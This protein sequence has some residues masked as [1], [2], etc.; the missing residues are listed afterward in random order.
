MADG[1]CEVIN[2]NAALSDQT[3][4][5]LAAL[6]ADAPSFITEVVSIV[7]G[8]TLMASASLSDEINGISTARV[9][10]SAAIG[11]AAFTIG[12]FQGLAEEAFGAADRV[13]FTLVDTLEASAAIT[14]AAVDS[15]PITLLHESATL[16]DV[17]LPVSGRQATALESARL[18]DALVPVKS[19]TLGDA[20]AVSDA[21]LGTL[22]SV[23]VINESGAF[24]DEVTSAG[25]AASVLAESGALSDALQA[26]V[27]A[28]AEVPE[29]ATIEGEAVLAASGAAWAAPTD[30]FAM[31]RWL[32]RDANSIAESDGALLVAGPGGIFR[33]DDGA[34]DAGGE[35][36][37]AQVR[38][39]LGD[40]GTPSLKRTS[41]FYLGYQSAGTLRVT[42][43]S[44]P[45][46]VEESY[47]YLF[48]PRRAEVPVPGKAKLGRG[49]RARYWRITLENVDG[50][51]FTVH[52]ALMD[53]EAMSRRA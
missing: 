7:V 33:M 39:G 19:A 1:L 37:E 16:S 12:T 53:V 28:Q 27:S 34:D 46:G 36:I 38:G 51:D 25:A 5:T 52:E 49:Q 47:S 3:L 41:A 31:S 2:E 20:A 9:E 8:A 13:R 29:E 6:A 24:A 48:P 35:L 11:D 45:S 21:A 10:E 40:L 18:S 42:V 26:T 15:E 50:A 23:E 17:A 30:T 32:L 43:G 44:I 14:D 22:P 4:P